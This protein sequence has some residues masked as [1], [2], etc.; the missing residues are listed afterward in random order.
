M[1]YTVIRQKR[2]TASIVINDKLEVL[3]K[4][5]NYVTNKAI[6]DFIRQHETWILETLEKK[7]ALYQKNDWYQTKQILYLG[8]YWPV[9][10]ISDLN[11]KP[12]VY[13]KEGRFIVISNGSE[14]IARKEMEK[15]FKKQAKEMLTELANQYA[16]KLGVSYQ[17]LTIRKQA[18]R[19]G[20]CSSKGN[21]SFN[22]KI[23][24]AP[25]EVIAYVVLHEIVHLKHFNH[26]QDFWE[27]VAKWIPDYKVRMNY[28]KQFGQNFIL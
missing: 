3:V 16:I 22:M 27:E 17:K 5:P 9:E 10:L 8:T 11:K 20:S 1:R 21:L 2:K 13:R 4:V 19:W 12:T 6:E 18:T 28:F 24:C 15:F 7:R 25:L 14:N 26:S 23:L